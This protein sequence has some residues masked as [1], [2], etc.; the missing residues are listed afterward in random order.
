MKKIAVAALM[1]ISLVSQSAMGAVYSSDAE[2]SVKNDIL[3]VSG[4]A[5]GGSEVT[6][7]VLPYDINPETITSAEAGSVAVFNMS[8]TAADGSYEMTMGL[9]EN[10]Q[11]GMY[12][13]LVY[14]QDSVS[15]VWFSYADSDKVK[16]HLG[17][18]NS[19]SAS[20]IASVIKSNASD[21]GAES[22]L[23]EKYSDVIGS[24]LYANRPASGYTADTLVSECTAAIALAMIKSGDES[25]EDVL[26]RFAKYIGIDIQKDYAPYSDSVKKD[27]ERLIKADSFSKGSAKDIYS[28][29]LLLARINK[30]ESDSDLQSIVIGN[31]DVMGLSLSEYNKLPNTY[32]QVR[33]F[34]KML[35]N[36]FSDFEEVE[37]AFDAAVDYVAD[38]EGGSS[39]SGG[40]GGG[41]SSSGG[42][43]SGGSFGGGSVTNTPAVQ[44]QAG[45][46]FADMNGHWAQAKVESLAALGIVNG[47][48]DGT[49]LPEKKVTRAEFSKMLCLTLGLSG[50]S[51]RA[52]FADVAS[53]DWYAPYVL[54]LSGKGIVN[55]YNG[56]FN[57]ESNITRQDAAV[58]TWRALQLKGV[59]QGS[60]TSFADGDSVSDYARESVELLAGLGI[61]NGY[62]GSFNPM[63]NTTRAET[64]SI[65]NNVLSVLK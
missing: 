48:S 7:V 28:K 56:S 63:G 47:Y 22:E 15:E 23:A 17:A 33:V 46:S 21:L 52:D 64:A 1:S 51:Y 60:K 57:P 20:G 37:S 58:M 8:H 61:I 36:S 49:F 10:W 30:A 3:T 13:A 59:A 62:N 45:I 35:G 55:G 14:Q 9:P 32:K 11:G 39:G 31:A 5:D 42:G 27:F 12:K 18:I 2:F 25:T 43:I 50:D 54:A 16:S 26:G 40:G 19:A 44:A 6:M 34:G 29:N 4:L 53:D 41:G 65:L 38:D 24:Y